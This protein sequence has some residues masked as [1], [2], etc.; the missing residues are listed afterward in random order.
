[1][2]IFNKNLG[3]P[4]EV[5]DIRVTLYH[6]P[7]EEGEEKPNVIVEYTVVGHKGEWIDWQHYEDFK[8]ANPDVKI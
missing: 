6:L 1:M 3:E 7:D 8:K 2:K 4:Q 5:R